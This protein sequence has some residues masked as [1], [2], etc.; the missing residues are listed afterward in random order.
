MSEP[1]GALTVRLHQATPIPLDVEFSCNP[2]EVLALV[3]PS[4]SG[5][6]TILR[7]IAGLYHPRNGRVQSGSAVWFD[8]TRRKQLPPQLRRVGMVFQHYA[9]FPH[10]S[11]LENVKI[12]LRH[13]PEPQRE[14]RARQLLARVHLSGVHDRRP[15]Q[16]SGG[17]QQRVAL[18]RALARE[19]R[20]LLLDEPFSAVDQVTRRKLR[21]ELAALTRTLNI[22]II[23]VTHDLDEA[24]MLGRRMCILRAG[25]T[26]QV[27]VP[28]EVMQ[29]PR[30]A[31]VARLMD[32]RN[33]FSGIMA[34]APEQGRSRLVWN[35]QILELPY[36]SD[37][38]PGDKVTWCIP[39]DQVLL[40][41]KDRP[42]SRGAGENPVDAVVSEMVTIGG[43]TNV[44][45]TVVG[46]E[47]DRLHMD[48]PPHVVKRNRLAIGDRVRMSLLGESIHLMPWH[49]LS[50]RPRSEERP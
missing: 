49:P 10:L 44:L 6:S 48:L 8:S 43:T 42:A 40:H 12:A 9:L 28:N 26:L 24:C 19:P 32:V 15:A 29:R 27:G 45:L 31:E 23:L 50:A 20:V 11:A 38:R 17:E 16:L 41:R 3:G 18:A 4:G 39:P 46:S 22:P 35:E 34:D 33:I 14:E 47:G 30:D 37:F 25:R 1:V 13:L 5:K 7:A 2:G 21:L 36:R